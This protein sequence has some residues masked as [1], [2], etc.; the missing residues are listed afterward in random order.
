LLS[1]GIGNLAWLELND[2]EGIIDRGRK[3]TPEMKKK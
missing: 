2:A 3:D 1:S